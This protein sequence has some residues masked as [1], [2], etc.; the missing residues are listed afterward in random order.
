MAKSIMPKDAFMNFA[1][2]HADTDASA[3][4]T[5]VEAVLNTGLSIRGMLI[6]LIHLVEVHVP[7]AEID[8]EFQYCLSTRQGLASMP[9]LIDDGVI[10][11]GGLQ[12]KLTTSG[13]AIL[14]KP[15]AM[16]YLPPIPI[17]T[18]QVSLYVRAAPDDA[19]ARNKPCDMRIGFTTAP[20]D[21][22]AYTE[23]AETWGW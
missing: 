3:S 10:S 19:S 2:L 9:D 13:L 16:H 17:A 1:V 22:A 12:T 21:A 8:M 20:L 18:P 4:D 15:H 14:E 6:W 23:I 11:R 7:M 5:L